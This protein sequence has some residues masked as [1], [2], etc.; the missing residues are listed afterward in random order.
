[1]WP[2]EFNYPQFM[3]CHVRVSVFIDDEL[4]GVFAILDDGTNMD[5]R[6]VMPDGRQLVFKNGGHPRTTD[7]RMTALE[8]VNYVLTEYKR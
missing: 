3:D 4:K 5:V 1:M 8:L 7:P 2:W 6:T